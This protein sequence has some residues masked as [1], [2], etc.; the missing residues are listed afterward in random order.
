MERPTDQASAD[1]RPEPEEVRNR[2]D[3]AES[4]DDGARLTALEELHAALQEEI[5]AEAP[6]T[7]R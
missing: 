2:L 5:D 1:A 7:G 3:A 6:P 4:E